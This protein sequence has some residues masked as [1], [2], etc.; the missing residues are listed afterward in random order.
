MAEAIASAIP[1]KTDGHPAG[2]DTQEQ[3]F[4]LHTQYQSSLVGEIAPSK[5]HPTFTP[6]GDLPYDRIQ[7]L[8]RDHTARFVYIRGGTLTVGRAEDNDIVLPDM[9]ISQH[10]ARVEYDG[11]NYSIVDLKSTNGIFQD[12]AKLLP[13]LAVVWQPG[14]LVQ[15]G[16][17]WLQLDL[18]QKTYL[19]LP[20][21]KEEDVGIATI[22]DT[23]EV[24]T[25]PPVTPDLTLQQAVTQTFE[26]VA[27]APVPKEVAPEPARYDLE[28]FPSTQMNVVEGSF[29]INLHNLGSA[30]LLVK[31]EA[32]CSEENI[33]FTFDHTQVEL[34]P[35]AEHAKTQVTF[36][37]RQKT[38]LGG[39]QPHSH[40]F[41]IR[42]YPANQP[43]NIHQV[44]A[45][46]IQTPPEIIGTLLAAGSTRK[47]RKPF[48]LELVNKSTADLTIQ[49]EDSDPQNT[50]SYEFQSP[51]IRLK[52]G[53]KAILPLTIKQNIT[54]SPDD[55]IPYPFMVTARVLEAPAYQTQFQGEWVKM[56]Q[57]ISKPWQKFFAPPYL[58]AWFL[59]ILGWAG[60][61]LL[62]DIVQHNICTDCIKYWL[63]NR[64]VDEG[65]TELLLILFYVLA[66][67]F[68]NG[69]LTGIALRKANH[70]LSIGAIL[71]ITLTWIF[72]ISGILTCST[73]LF[74]SIPWFLNFIQGAIGGLI[75]G[76]ILMRTRLNPIRFLQALS[77]MVAW[78]IARGI[79][80]WILDKFQGYFIAD[81]PQDVFLGAVMAI[82]AGGWT[83]FVMYQSQSREP[84]L[85][86]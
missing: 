76:L 68:I 41:N 37:I 33:L 50:L 6:P 23:G 42:A 43:E 71:L 39:D 78:G 19:R 65:G 22:V 9:N 2:S 61:P 45:E 18:A 52:A 4:T 10:H 31:L 7:I 26:Q 36:S 82:A 75:T 53:G 51:Q 55:N 44:S 5:L 49:L 73:E 77:I 17:Y 57:A 79:G 60:A 48:N 83:L 28:V 69:L 85:Q 14:K 35:E 27:V 12:G 84:A 34:L 56:P 66:V 81:I 38:P 11:K 25:Q 29:S 86:P 63:Y 13:G 46:W 20:A 70:S 47:S 40:S 62:V 59:M 15:I 8:S 64:G 21:K 58:W 16:D 32:S 30:P 80:V 3:V 1:T 67:S 24:Q 72:S 54:I 74:F